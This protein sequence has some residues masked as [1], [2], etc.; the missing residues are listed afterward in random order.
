MMDSL[1]ACVLVTCLC[2]Q[3]TCILLVK[4]IYKLYAAITKCKL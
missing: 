3:L 4:F 2:I 1:V